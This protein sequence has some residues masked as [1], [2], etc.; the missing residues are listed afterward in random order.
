MKYNCCVV[1]VVENR[2]SVVIYNNDE[3]ERDERS[4][5]PIYGDES[6]AFVYYPRSEYSDGVYPLLVIEHMINVANN[7]I[8]K[9][10]GNVSALA[11]LITPSLLSK[12]GQGRE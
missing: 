4:E 7:Q 2:V 8:A 3:T 11:S 9:L 10:K 6:Y 12:F 1:S 5:H